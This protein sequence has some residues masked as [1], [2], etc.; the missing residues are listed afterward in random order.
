MAHV[1]PIALPYNLQVF[2]YIPSPTY[3]RISFNHQLETV[4]PQKYVDR[5][6]E[7]LS[8]KLSRHCSRGPGACPEPFAALRV[9]SVEGWPAFVGFNHCDK[10][11]NCACFVCRTTTYTT[12]GLFQSFRAHWQFQDFFTAITE[13]RS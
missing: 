10:R 12:E 6:L 4:E 2:V 11:C 8:Y 7:H 3:S 9:N 5:S 1:Y 13:E